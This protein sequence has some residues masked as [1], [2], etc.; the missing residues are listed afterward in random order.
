MVK[1]VLLLA[2]IP[3]MS[4]CLSYQ[5]SACLKGKL[6]GDVTA[7]EKRAKTLSEKGFKEGDFCLGYILLSEGK[8]E[9]AI[10]YLMRAYRK[11]F[12]KAAY[13]LGK[14][15]EAVGDRKKAA[16]WY[17]EDL[18]NGHITDK[19][20]RTTRYISGAQLKELNKIAKKHPIVY[21]YLGDYFFNSGFYDAAL[22]YYHIAI[23]YGFERAKFMAGLSLYKLGNR[24]EALNTFYSIYKEGNLRGAEEIASLLEKE[25]DRSAGCAAEEAR[26][27]EEFV[28]RKAEIFR[29]K[30]QLYKTAAEFYKLSKDTQGYRRVLKKMEYYSPNYRGKLLIPDSLN[31]SR[32]P[33]S[34]ALKQCR[35]GKEWAELFVASRRGKSFLK[36]AE[37]FYRAMGFVISN[38]Y[39]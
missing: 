15:Y 1:R 36:A 6:P 34:E 21:Q 29:R 28:K 10:P 12:K 39:H 20:F 23:R 38:H 30:E 37:E 22:Y 19:F 24:R 5:F 26:T 35:E 31:I 8:P 4:S 9:R 13:Y 25:A 27:P 32:V 17:F 33:Y 7:L 14:A 11:G 18:K 2:F 16:Y 3:L